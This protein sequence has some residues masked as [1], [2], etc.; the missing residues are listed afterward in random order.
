MNKG[1]SN[2]GSDASKI[3]SNG[4]AKHIDDEPEEGNFVI[5]RGIKITNK[6]KPFYYE[7][8]ILLL[9][10]EELKVYVIILMVL[11]MR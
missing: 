11:L 7:L 4:E 2:K 3:A 10:F 8:H 1:G 5:K 9:C 6:F